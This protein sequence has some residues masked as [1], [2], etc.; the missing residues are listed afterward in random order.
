[1]TSSLRRRLKVGLILPNNEWGMDGETARWSDFLAMARTAEDAGFDS[2]WLADH[3]LYR[4]EGKET[5]GT[6]ECWSTLSALAAVTRKVELG[7]FV[8]C[9]G[10]RNPALLAKMADNIDDISGGRLVLG[11]GAGWHEPEFR[12]YGYPFDHRV[13]RFAEAL[14]I[15]TSLL[16]DGHVD[17]AGTYYQ[18]PNC[19]LKRRGPR[20]QGPPIMMGT[21]RERMLRL[22]AQYA[23]LWNVYFW[24][25]GTANRVE[26]V[27]ELQA[28]VDTACRAVGRDPVTLQRTAAVL[29][30]AIPDN[31]STRSTAEPVLRPLSG[32][33][34]ELSADLR[35]Y[36]AAG[37]TEVQLWLYPNTVAGIES[38]AP[39]LGLLD[40]S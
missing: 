24:P 34:E 29:V 8:A 19:E 36:A 22:T 39:V 5:R 15:I 26:R 35:A 40:Q 20:S 12:A 32:S 17:F 10:F 23:D 7:S 11:L 4:F 18:A 27:P 31:S 3:L 25:E 30:S 16:R 33:P 9:T 37:I 1:V 14:T 28:I 38:F 21:T 13:S 2:L 6:A